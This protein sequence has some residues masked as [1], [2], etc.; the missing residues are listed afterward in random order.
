MKLRKGPVIR[1]SRYCR[2]CDAFGDHHT[3]R[4]PCRRCSG[5]GTVYSL[6]QLYPTCEDCGGS[7]MH[8]TEEE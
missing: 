4:H 3:D 8:H 6:D 5:K 1:R 7:G 2:I